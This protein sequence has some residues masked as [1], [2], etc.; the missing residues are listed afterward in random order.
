MSALPRHYV[1]GAL[2]AGR[3]RHLRVSP[4]PPLCAGG[5]SRCEGETRTCLPCPTTLGGERFTLLGRDTYVS[6]PSRHYVRGALRAVRARHLRVSPA[7]PLCAGSATRW[8]GETLA[9]QPLPAT[10]CG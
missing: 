2:R 1:R 9:C 5:A 8:E 7:P 3:A 4:F 10:M 6:A